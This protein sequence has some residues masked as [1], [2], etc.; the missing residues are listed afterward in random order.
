MVKM[1][2]PVLDAT[3]KGLRAPVPCTLKATVEEEALTPTTIPLS[4]RVE[5][6]RVEE[7]SHLVA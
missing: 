4:M 7:V 2:T 3:L 1:L 6:A 5:V